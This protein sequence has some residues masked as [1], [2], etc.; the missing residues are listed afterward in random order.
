MLKG[1]AIPAINLIKSCNLS[2]INGEINGFKINC[3]MI[4]FKI[5]CGKRNLQALK[6]F[7]VTLFFETKSKASGRNGNDIIVN[8]CCPRDIFLRLSVDFRHNSAPGI[9]SLVCEAQADNKILFPKPK[10]IINSAKYK[11]AI[12]MSVKRKA[13]GKPF[14]KLTNYEKI[15]LGLL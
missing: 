2:E 11:D 12:S 3:G 6:N 9:F 8:A 4:S 14:S 15:K 7:G 13:Q 5:E 1:Y 10:M